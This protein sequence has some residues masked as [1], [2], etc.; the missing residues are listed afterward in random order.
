M[1][2]ISCPIKIDQKV[3]TEML[4]EPDENLCLDEGLKFNCQ[5]ISVS[6]TT[7]KAKIYVTNT[8]KHD[9]VLPAKTFIGCIER[10]THCYPVNVD[11]GHI[12]SIVAEDC[13][14]SP[15]SPERPWDPPVNLGHLSTEQQAAVMEMLK[16]ESSVFAKHNDEVGYIKN[17][18]MDIKLTDEIPVAKAYNAVPRALY[19]E[20]KNHIQ[21]LLKKGFI[22]K[23]TSPYASPVVCVRKRDGSLRLCID[24]RGLNKKTI[25]DR[26]PIPRIQEI[27]DGLGG[28]MWFSV[29][30]QGKAYHQGEISEDS[31]KYTAFTTP[32]G[33]YEWNRI[34]FG[35][36]NAPSAFQRS[37]EESLEG[38]RDIICTPYLDDVL[39]Y[40]RTFEQHVEDLRSVF[41]RQ[42]AWGLSLIHI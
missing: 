10:V 11:Q 30:D 36:T 20:V 27:L 24:Y 37:M 42:Q 2:C 14:N 33:L 32:W 12:N 23:S 17:L 5:L 26:H 21:D 8:K 13:P 39:V 18:K 25:P 7:R 41:K 31:K 1:H 15:N 4:F 16:Q 22:R 34:P 29:L 6:G 38:L 28:N 9:I 3:K 40:S 19:D 35:L